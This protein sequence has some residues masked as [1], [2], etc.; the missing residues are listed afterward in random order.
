MSRSL[1]IFS[2]IIIINMFKLLIL[3]M[4]VIIKITAD[5]QTDTD[6]NLIPSEDLIMSQNVM[7]STLQAMSKNIEAW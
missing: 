6:V 5:S 3:F 1:N 4:T 7:L 2:T